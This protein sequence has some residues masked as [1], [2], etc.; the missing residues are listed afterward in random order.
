MTGPPREY[1]REFT[2]PL[3]H[4]TRRRMG[5]SHERGVVT[6]FVVQ[7]EYR[8]DSEYQE[9]VR[10]DHDLSNSEGHDVTDEGLH[11]DVYRCGEKVRVEQ[12]FPPMPAAKALTFAEEHLREHAQ[13]YVERFEEWH[14]IQ[15]GN[16]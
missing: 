9:V 4:R 3:T 5:Y 2:T 1:D 8:L 10:F 11:L 7:L 14:G 6:R 15:R 16:R 12:V 13:R